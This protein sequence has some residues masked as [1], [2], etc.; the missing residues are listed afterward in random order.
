MMAT[1]KTQ[2]IV[3]IAK[4]NRQMWFQPHPDPK[5]RGMYSVIELKDDRESYIVAPDLREALLEEW[6]PKMLVACQSRQGTFFLWPIRI[7]AT[8][9]R[10]DTWSDSAKK[11][12][13]GYAGKWIRV[14]PDMQAGG[15]S[16]IEPANTFPAPVWPKE[17]FKSL[18]LKAF[19]GRIIDKEDHPVVLKL[20]GQA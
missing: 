20:R 9:G 16:V 18:V 10:V 4:P 5:W 17:G 12:V 14:I 11:I 6:T 2:L 15:Y 13:D 8:D 7:P 19:N 1:S 3:P